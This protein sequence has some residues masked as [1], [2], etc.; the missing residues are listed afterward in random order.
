MPTEHAR[1]SA[2]DLIDALKQE[3]TGSHKL[4]PA[5]EWMVGR[6]PHPLELLVEMES[7]GVWG[8]GTAAKARQILAD[9]GIVEEGPAATHSPPDSVLGV[10]AQPEPEPEAFDQ[11]AARF[12]DLITGT[13]QIRDR[14]DRL[15]QRIDELEQ[16][17]QEQRAISQNTSVVV[18]DLV[19]RLDGLAV[20]GVHDTARVPVGP[21][22]APA[23]EP[24]TA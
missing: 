6:D 15:E 9:A 18:A 3:G 16:A 19:A 21:P 22:E 23:I 1:M 7:I 17:L 10:D 8:A 20:D 5:S 12:E 24:P 2:E 11:I 4:D 13:S 14:T